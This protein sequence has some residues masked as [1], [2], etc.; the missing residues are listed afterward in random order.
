M[1][2]K[3]RHEKCDPLC[4]GRDRSTQSCPFDVKVCPY[5]Y[6]NLSPP[7]RRTSCCG[8]DSFGS[9]PYRTRPYRARTTPQPLVLVPLAEA[10][11]KGGGD[12]LC[13]VDRQNLHNYIL[14]EILLKKVRRRKCDLLGPV[15]DLH[16]FISINRNIAQKSAT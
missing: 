3:V 7:V 6:H 13:P 4:G 16:N 14:V 8:V 5:N 10:T 11:N 1:L 2:K 15:D 9:M 12:R